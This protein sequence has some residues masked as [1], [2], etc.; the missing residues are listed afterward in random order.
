MDWKIWQFTDKGRID[1]YNG[2]ID[3]NVMKKDYFDLY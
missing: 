2:D 1:G 3:L